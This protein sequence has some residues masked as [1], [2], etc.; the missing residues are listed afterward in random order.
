LSVAFDR[1]TPL[2]VDPLAL[3]LPAGRV[4]ESLSPVRMPGTTTVCRCN[5]VSKKEIVSAWEAGADTVDAVAAATRATTGCGGCTEVVCGL[6]DW[7]GESDPATPLT[8]AT[9]PPGGGRSTVVTRR[10]TSA[11]STS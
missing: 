1:R 9:P 10:N 4:E 6:V 2:P 7:L 5:G 8:E 3:L 11:P